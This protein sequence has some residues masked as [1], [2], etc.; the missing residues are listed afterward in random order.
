MIP[1]G[2]RGFH[3]TRLFLGGIGV[4][5]MYPISPGGNLRTLINTFE[6]IKQTDEYVAELLNSLHRCQDDSGNKKRRELKAILS[7]TLV[8]YRNSPGTGGKLDGRWLGPCEVLEREVEHSYVLRTEQNK[9]IK[10]D[11]TYV[12]E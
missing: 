9:R 6:R 8:C 7:G 3:P 2:K 11:R 12:K 4:W 10:A 5:L 1:R